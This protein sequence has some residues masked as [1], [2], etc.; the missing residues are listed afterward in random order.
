MN[1]KRGSPEQVRD[2]VGVP[3]RK[4][5]MQMTSWPSAQEAVAEVRAEKPGAAGDQDAHARMRPARRPAGDARSA[6]TVKPSSR[7]TAG[8][9]RLRPSKM[10]G[11]CSSC[12]M[13]AKS[14]WRNSFQSVTMT[15]ASRAFEGLVVRVGD[16]APGRRR[17]RCASC[18]RLRVVRAA[19]AA[20][21]ASSSSISASAGASRMSSVCGLKASPQTATARPGSCAAE[22]GG[23]LLD[24]PPLLPVVGLF[25]RLEHGSGTLALVRGADQRLARPSGKHEPP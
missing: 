18:D 11:R 16:S 14:G 8:S 24:Q 20:P 3:V 7:I 1:L 13:R 2:V 5:S 10:I 17:R 4:L 12:F 21:A 9:Y 19:P 23:H 6:G 22:R 15:S 25:D